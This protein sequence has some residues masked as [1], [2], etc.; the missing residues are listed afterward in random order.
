MWGWP[1]GEAP[2]GESQAEAEAEAEAEKE[3]EE[4]KREASGA[5][6]IGPHAC[7][8]GRAQTRPQTDCS[9]HC[10]LGQSTVHGAA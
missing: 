8:H 6:K 3:K 1:D 5:V 9:L 4:E 10:A 7:L 2:E